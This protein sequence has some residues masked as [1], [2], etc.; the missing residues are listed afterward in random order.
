[1]TSDSSEERNAMSPSELL[2]WAWRETRP[3]H[4]NHTNR[5]IHLFAVPLFIIGNVLIFAGVISI[6]GFSL[7][8]LYASS[9]PWRFKNMA[10][11]WSGRQFIRSWRR[12][13][14]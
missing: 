8:R 12:A 6:R 14:F 11:R 1:M 7:Q 13:T 10:I 3:L 2:A 5:L 9:L 4:K